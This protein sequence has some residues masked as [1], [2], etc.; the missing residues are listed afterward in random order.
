[1]CVYQA[2]PCCKIGEK[3]DLK[4][5]TLRE[6]ERVSENLGAGGSDRESEVC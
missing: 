6:R 4:E 3:V 5:S 2:V 1:M